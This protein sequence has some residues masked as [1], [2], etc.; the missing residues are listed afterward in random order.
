VSPRARQ[1]ALLTIAA[2]LVIFQATQPGPF[3]AFG[4]SSAKA[5]PA[6]LV[7]T[8]PPPT[9]NAHAGHPNVRV[10]QLVSSMNAMWEQTFAAAGDDYAPPH[11]D[12][13]DQELGEGCGGTM[14]GWAGI[15]CS[16]DKS[17]VINLGAH[18]VVRAAVGDGDADDR[19]GY[20]L[21]HEVG[22]HV[23]NLRGAFNSTDAASPLHVRRA[24]LHAEC[25]AGVWGR[26]AGRGLPPAW[27][28]ESD[29]AHGTA[30]EQRAWLERGYARAR[31]ADCDAVWA[32]AV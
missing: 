16:R 19:L 32:A 25:L 12:S 15:Y 1:L 28:Y 14:T 30:A 13:R 17:I 23:Q 29:A 8:T 10:L 27:T 21:A 24:E 5:F 20:V 18:V 2:V 26:A 6:E 11:I 9:P 31:P 3:L 4:G 7:A 22:H